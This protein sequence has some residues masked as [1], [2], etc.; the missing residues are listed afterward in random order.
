V[1]VG[2]RREGHQVERPV[3]GQ[4]QPVD[5]RERRPQRLDE[6]PEEFPCD[7]LVGV[8]CWIA[9]RSTKV[10]HE[11]VDVLRRAQIDRRRLA[12]APQHVGDIARHA[13]FRPVV[14]T[15]RVEGLV[16]KPL[17]QRRVSRQPLPHTL[18]GDRG[19]GLAK[20]RAADREFPFQPLLLVAKGVQALAVGW[21]GKVARPA[22]GEG[23]ELLRHRGELIKECLVLRVDAAAQQSDTAGHRVERPALVLQRRREPQR[24]G[25][26]IGRRQRE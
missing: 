4:E 7:L 15:L 18:E 10:V 17:D 19:H 11:L 22:K 12:L 26:W 3:G 6:L 13:P 5:A 14:T 21:S 20:C 16:A 1:L 2:E 24:P 25:A 9:Q 8:A 23:R